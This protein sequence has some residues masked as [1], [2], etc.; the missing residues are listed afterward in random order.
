M[1]KSLLNNINPKRTI[2]HN[3]IINWNDNNKSRKIINVV[4]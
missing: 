1:I 2:V 3:K 4:I